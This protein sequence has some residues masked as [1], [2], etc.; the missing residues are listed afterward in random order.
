VACVPTV[1][2]HSFGLSVVWGGM[3]QRT[4]LIKSRTLADYPS[5]LYSQLRTADC[6]LPTRM[7]AAVARSKR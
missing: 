2:S 5:T 6:L 7:V 1:N 4:G 3:E